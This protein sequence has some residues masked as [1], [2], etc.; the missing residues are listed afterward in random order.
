M[1]TWVLGLVLLQSQTAL[2]RGLALYRNHQFDRAVPALTQ[3]VRD[4]PANVE[5]RQ[6]LARA[7]IE[8]GR[9]PEALRQI[10]ALLER[11]PDN[12]EAMF[13]A[14][15]ILQDLAGTRFALM[16]RLAPE[17]PE[18]HEMLGRY[19]E[20]QNRL[21]EALAQYRSALKIKPDRPGLHFL[22][23]NV[24]WKQR[25]Y[26]A[27]APE[28][29]AELRVNPSHTMA[30]HRVGN[31]LIAQDE[32]PRAIAYL[33][34]AVAAD[35][36]FLDARRDLGKAYRMAGRFDDALRE[37][38]VVAERRPED[39]SVHAQLAI[40]YRSLGNPEQAAAEMTI[41]RKILRKRSQQAQ[42]QPPEPE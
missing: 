42:G 28:L 27:A 4:D 12:P 31:I 30:N 9:T 24:L 33:E 36:G 18:T 13:E 1:F 14:G 7:L 38:K 11:D 34:K 29:M 10:R 37:L 8:A 26:E 23:G 40:V 20:A 39:D 22:I 15:R 16:E 5:A 3:A 32:A 2:E 41:Q 19:Y 35:A 6:W 25:D 21:D 17:S